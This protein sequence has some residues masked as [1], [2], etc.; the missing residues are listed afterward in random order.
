MKKQL[1]SILVVL[2]VQQ[3]VWAQISAGQVESDLSFALSR[4][5]GITDFSGNLRAGWFLDS[6]Q[7]IEARV[8]FAKVNRAGQ[9]EFSAHYL[10]HPELFAATIRPYLLVGA[11]SQVAFVG[12][13]RYL[14]PTV[15]AGVGGKFFHS[16]R[17]ATRLE[18]LLQRVY[19]TGF[20]FFQVDVLVGFSVFFGGSN[21]SP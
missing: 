9:V 4:A 21:G 2:A 11:G 18:V 7:Q 3:P 20:S 8:G 12:S 16:P 17:F 1:F 5:F 14:R 13:F 10:I 6:R 19:A 15:V